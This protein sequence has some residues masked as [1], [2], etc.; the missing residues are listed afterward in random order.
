M[1]EADVVVDMP[2]QCICDLHPL[3]VDHS[4]HLVETLNRPPKP[5][6]KPEF[7]EFADAKQNTSW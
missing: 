7:A 2:H 1:K 5:V 4:V 3:G 6:A